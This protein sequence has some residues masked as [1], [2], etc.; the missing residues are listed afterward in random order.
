MHDADM[1]FVVTE[2]FKLV[3]VFLLLVLGMAAGINDHK[4]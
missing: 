1:R 2:K 3:Y 4:G